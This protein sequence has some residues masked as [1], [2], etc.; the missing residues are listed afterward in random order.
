MGKPI[1]IWFFICCVLWLLVMGMGADPIGG[2][3]IV[4]LLF[5][6][7]C[8]VIGFFALIGAAAR[9]SR[10]PYRQACSSSSPVI[11]PPVD[12]IERRRKQIED[13][14]RGVDRTSLSADEKAA[15]KD[16]LKEKLANL[17]LEDGGE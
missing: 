2:A 16:S 17:Y 7:G 10:V 3:F 12:P 4:F 15:L 5:A 11:T 6:P 9:G 1:S 13:R 8:L 14:I